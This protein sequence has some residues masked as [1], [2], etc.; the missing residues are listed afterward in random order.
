MPQEVPPPSAVHDLVGVGFGPS[1]LG[2]A[3]ALDE[4]GSGLTTRFVER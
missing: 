1:N 2:L 4:Q 3:I